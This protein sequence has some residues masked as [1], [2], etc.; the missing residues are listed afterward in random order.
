[1]YKIRIRV[2]KIDG[3]CPVLNET[4]EYLVDEDGQTLRIVKGDKLC[5]YALSS[6]IPFLPTLSR[7]LPSGFWMN[8]D[9]I[10]F[11][12]PDP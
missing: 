11:T 2:K 5:L 7:D 10:Y 4:D 6:L 12:C 8:K 3:K 1:M 9:L